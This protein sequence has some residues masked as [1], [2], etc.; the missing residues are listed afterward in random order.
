MIRKYLELIKFSHTLFALPF[1]LISMLVAARGVP[2]AR[3]VIWILVA[4]VSARTMAMSFNRIVDRVIDAQNPRTALRPSVTGAVTIR[5]AWILWGLACGIF[6]ASCRMLNPLCLALSPVVVI[7]LNGYSYAKRFTHWTHLWLGLSLG[8]SPLGAWAAVTGTLSL[9]PVPLALAVL[10]WVAGF[11]IIYALQDEEFDRG[12]GL[13]SLVVRHGA[14]RALALSRL[15]H[16]A[17]LAL[18]G[19]FGWL[20]HLGLYYFSGV[21]LV[22]VAL[23]VE[24]SLVSAEDRSRV[25]AAFFTANGF[26]SLS[27]LAATC[28]DLFLG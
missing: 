27:L 28:L 6:L 1:A 15:F 19:G 14:A 22:G 24:Q 13:H 2:E 4:M 25:N 8:I 26:V 7:V 10:L 11:D 12:L 23:A 18:L 3:T 20:L 5:G 21:G 16:A 17:T 9:E